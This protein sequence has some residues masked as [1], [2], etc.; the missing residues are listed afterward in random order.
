MCNSNKNKNKYSYGFY[1]N[2]T[3]RIRINDRILEQ[4]NIFNYLGYNISY[5]EDTIWM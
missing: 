1:R 2:G 4:A 5:E 3:N